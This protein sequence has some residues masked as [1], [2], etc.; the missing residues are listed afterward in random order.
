MLDYMQKSKQS[1]ALFGGLHLCLFVTIEHWNSRM[2][3]LIEDS[4]SWAG[5]VVSEN[6]P[7]WWNSIWKWQQQSVFS[8]F[9]LDKSQNC[10]QKILDLVPIMGFFFKFVSFPKVGENFQLFWFFFWILQFKFPKKFKSF[11]CHHV[12]IRP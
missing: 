6:P 9:I 12:K 8:S 2:K 10:F 7:Q 4:D 1:Q 3:V 11:Y 5:G